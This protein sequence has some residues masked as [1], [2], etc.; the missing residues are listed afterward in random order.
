LRQK[1]SNWNLFIG[2]LQAL[3]RHREEL[4]ALRSE[5]LACLSNVNFTASIYLMLTEYLTLLDHQIADLQNQIE[6]HIDRHLGLK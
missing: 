6:S 2:Q 1:V 5:V 4:K 3:T